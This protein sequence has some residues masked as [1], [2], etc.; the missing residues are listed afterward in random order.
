MVRFSSLRTHSAWVGTIACIVLS[1][2]TSLAQPPAPEAPP[3]AAAPT[4]PP[5]AMA[6]A[7]TAP[8]PTAPPAP[9]PAP[10]VTAAPSPAMPYAPPPPSEPAEGP[11][12]T[13]E[14]PAEP[15]AYGDFTWLNGTN[16]Q[17]KALLDSDI[18]RHLPSR[19][20][21]YIV[22]QPS[23]RRHGRRL[24]GAVPRQ[25]SHARFRRVW[26]DFHYKNAR[27]RLLTQFGIRSELVPRNDFST[28][29]GSSTCKT[30]S[31]TSA[32]RT[33]ACTSTYS[34]ASTSTPVFPRRTWDCF[35]TTTSKTGITWRRT[36]PILTPW[37]FNGVRIQ[38]FPSD[39]LKIEPWSINGWQTYGVFNEMPGF[40]D[41]ILW[42]P[43][44]WVSV[45]A[46]QY[47]GWD[48]QDNPGQL[49][50]HSDNSATIPELY[51][52]PSGGFITKMAESWTF[53]IGGQQGDGVTAFGGKRHRGALHHQD[54]VH[55]AVFERDGLPPHLSSAITSRSRSEVASCTCRA[56]TCSSRRPARRRGPRKLE[57]GWRQLHPCYQS[58]RLQPLCQVRRRGRPFRLPV[59]ADRA[60]HLQRRKATTPAGRT[61]RTLRATAASRRPT[62]TSPPRYRRAGGR[63][64]SKTTTGI[65]FAA[66]VRF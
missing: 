15:F 57:R 24:D 13:K 31:G 41:Q 28:F 29:R 20:Q 42:R 60:G 43:N 64:W 51:D 1:E 38:I 61:C 63:I 46:N 25:R 23:H 34:T 44:E 21:L 35:H 36:R 32:K 10:P 49:R 30:P 26:R 56:A 58:L 12:P 55:I 7:P 40:G 66:L 9:A 54:P 45:L 59:H 16:R 27:A 2:G 5:A 6:P 4:A 52:N 14:K 19:R 33:A 47:V 3:S 48:T 11:A 39:R 62:A 50:F 8:A 65:I 53:D 18:Y 17:H 37:S 22:A